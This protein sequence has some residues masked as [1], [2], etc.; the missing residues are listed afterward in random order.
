MYLA[1]QPAE[2]AALKKLTELIGVIVED[3][4]QIRPPG[5]PD[6]RLGFCRSSGSSSPGAES[7][8]PLRR[9]TSFLIWTGC[10]S[11]S[12][13]KTTRTFPGTFTI[14]DTACPTFPTSPRRDTR[15]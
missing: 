5:P 13:F 14:A 10:G 15:R 7:G 12:L 1:V 3:S 6:F 8:R 2:A 9:F 4:A 11:M